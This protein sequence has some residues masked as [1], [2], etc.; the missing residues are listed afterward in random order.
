MTAK[1]I[2]Q[3]IARDV[4]LCMGAIAVLMAA[5]PVILPHLAP[6][7]FAPDDGNS[8]PFYLVWLVIGTLYLVC[9]YAI[10]TRKRWAPVGAAIVSGLILLLLCS[11]MGHPGPLLFVIGGPMTFT[12]L[13]GIANRGR[14]I[15]FRRTADQ[16]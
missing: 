1:P 11:G 8:F 5:L 9:A 2:W 16:Q 7:S 13:W 15:E 3:R 4:F 6:D 14:A 12:L 10:H